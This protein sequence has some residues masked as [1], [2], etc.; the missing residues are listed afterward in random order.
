LQDYFKIFEYFLDELA[1]TYNAKTYRGRG[2]L[3]WEPERGFHIEASLQSRGTGAY[4]MTFGGARVL[5][6]EDYPTIWMKPQH[7]AW[8]VAPRVVM[9]G[10][11]DVLDRHW[12]SIP[13]QRV[14]IAKHLKH[15]YT[16]S[17]WDGS[18]LYGITRKPRL[19]D[20]VKTEVQIGQQVVSQQSSAAGIKYDDETMTLTGRQIDESTF[21]LYWELSKSHWS[22]TTSWIF[23]EAVR[24]ALSI[25]WG[26]TVA[27]L[28]RQIDRDGLRYTDIRTRQAVVSVAPYYPFGPDT[29]FDK[30]VFE[31]LVSLFLLDTELANI[32]NNIFD[33]IAQAAQQKDWQPTE[34]L[35]S[36]ILEAVLRTSQNKP[37]RM[38]K[39][40]DTYNLSTDLENFRQKYLSDK[41]GDVCNAVIRAHTALRDRNAHPDWIRTLGGAIS[42]EELAKAFNQSIFLSRFY[43]I[44]IL[45]LVGFENLAPTE[46]M[47]RYLKDTHS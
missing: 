18:A 20:S 41:W 35:I 43:G 21:E 14:V 45:A 3:T 22:R 36:T 7:Q 47:D 42:E 31:R 33:Q 4:F 32:C 28:Y 39:R 5:T 34:L 17:H 9:L 15:D 1:F 19:P 44:M 37:F 24:Q 38:K 29:A 25:M 2:T 10:R 6:K 30:R 16:D 23:A 46:E 8:A 11:F 12:L 13:V 40:K 26:Q 27:L